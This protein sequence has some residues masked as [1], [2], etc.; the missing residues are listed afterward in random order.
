MLIELMFALAVLGLVMLPIAYSFSH[1]QKLCRAYYHRAAAMEIV[2]GEMEVLVAGEW[3]KFKG[4]TH[5]YTPRAETAKNLPPGKFALT[6]GHGRVTLEWIPERK[7]EGGV[8]RREVRV[9]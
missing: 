9:P 3:R 4:G 6:V 7:G 1:E 5:A 8:V 2:D